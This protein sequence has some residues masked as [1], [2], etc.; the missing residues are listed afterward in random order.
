MAG[1]Q[2]GGRKATATNKQRYG[3]D[4]YP[5]IGRKGVKISRGGGFSPEYVYPDGRTGRDLA[6]EAGQRGGK[7]SRRSYRYVE[8]IGTVAEK[9]CL[10]CGQLIL[11][12]EFSQHVAKHLKAAA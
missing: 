12:D 10:T 3:I 2:A 8:G 7:A 11:I 4:F 6:V 1:T 9:K 5:Q